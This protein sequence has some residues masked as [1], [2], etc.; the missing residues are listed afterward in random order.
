M[1][2]ISTKSHYMGAGASSVIVTDATLDLERLFF[3]GNRRG[4]SFENF[5]NEILRNYNDITAYDPVNKFSERTRDRWFCQAIQSPSLQVSVS[6]VMSNSDWSLEK[7]M[8]FVTMFIHDNKLKFGGGGSGRNVSAF[9]GKD[10]RGCGHGHGG[11][12]RGGRSGRGSCGQDKFKN[13]SINAKVDKYYPYKEYVSF[14]KE[15]KDKLRE[16][17]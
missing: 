3:N 9:G 5:C 17:K 15:Q 16:L 13:G 14:T 10:G 12:G 2:F 7:S 11:V 1:V 6:Q 8:N 4:Y